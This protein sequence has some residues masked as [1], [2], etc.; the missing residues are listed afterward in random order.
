MLAEEAARGNTKLVELLLDHGSSPVL[1][2]AWGES[3]LSEAARG[4]TAAHVATLE[5]MLKYVTPVEAAMGG[6]SPSTTEERAAGWVAQAA[7]PLVVA[8]REAKQP[9]EEKK[10]H[11]PQAAALVLVEFVATA[12]KKDASS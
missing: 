4:G 1:L 5:A 2:D 12:W 7:K 10:Q 3:P 8:I 6:E 11:D 9:T